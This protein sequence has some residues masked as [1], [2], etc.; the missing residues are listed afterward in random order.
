MPYAKTT[1]A[2]FDAVITSNGCHG[3]LGDKLV[4]DFPMDKAQIDEV[5][6]FM[7]KEGIVY[8]LDNPKVCYCNNMKSEMFLNWINKF[9]LPLDAFTENKGIFNDKIY[10]ISALFKNT[11]QAEEMQ[12][13][14]EGVFT[15]DVQPGTTFADVTRYCF[16]KGTGAKSFIEYY[17][18]PY[19]NTYAFG[20]SA[21]DISM[22]DAVCHGVA[23]GEHDP[24]LDDVC[25]YVTET[26]SREGIEKGLKHY[27][28]I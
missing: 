5:V 27:N 26:V 3:I 9:D 24:R 16:N 23:M 18:I 21:N 20:D 19:E 1:S 13:R 14:Y 25:E 17:N 7:E 4:A 2:Y 28:L 11:R 15:I 10:K 8:T 12:K 6:D 22:L